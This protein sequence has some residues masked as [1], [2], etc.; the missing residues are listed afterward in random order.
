MFHSGE[1][2]VCERFFA[3]PVETRGVSARLA[4]SLGGDNVDKRSY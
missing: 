2:D 3:P 4:E 1:S